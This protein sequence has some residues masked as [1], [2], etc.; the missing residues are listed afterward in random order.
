VLTTDLECVY[1][2][3][4]IT[5]KAETEYRLGKK[6]YPVYLSGSLSNV[7]TARANIRTAR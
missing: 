4:K 6:V 7:S 5:S 1:A 3:P 2:Q